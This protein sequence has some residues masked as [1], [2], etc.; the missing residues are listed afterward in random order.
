[1]FKSNKPFDIKINVKNS[2]TEE[3]A[4]SQKGARPDESPM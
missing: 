1:M 4:R 3:I 2:K